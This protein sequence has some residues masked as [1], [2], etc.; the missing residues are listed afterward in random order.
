MISRIFL[1]VFFLPTHKSMDICR[2]RNEIKMECPR[3]NKLY[4]VE[5][6][7]DLKRD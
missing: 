1:Q 4:E 5:F 7:V 3:E 6:E 2:L